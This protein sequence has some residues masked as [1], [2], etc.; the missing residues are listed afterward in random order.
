MASPRK[1]QATRKNK[2]RS[3]VR[4]WPWIAGGIVLAAGIPLAAVYLH[5]HGA[6]GTAGGKHP[7][8]PPAA[9]RGKAGD[10]G[11]ATVQAAAPDKP[12]FDFYRMLPKQ[13]VIVPGPQDDAQDH[14]GGPA[15]AID[16]KG[17][18]E[19]QVGSYRNLSDADRVRAKLALIGVEADIYTVKVNEETWHRLLIGPY[20][21]L[22]K[23]RDI[24]ARLRRNNVNYMVMK[25]KG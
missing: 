7:T 16:V 3:H 11:D 21:D 22:Q 20:S 4:K 24:T 19:L 13:Q 23:L 12:R 5:I 10:G 2:R 6:V 1:R 9:H 14:A 18:Y 15:E 8:V 17:T 25:I